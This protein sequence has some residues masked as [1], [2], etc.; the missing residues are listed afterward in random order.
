MITLFENFKISDFNNFKKREEEKLKKSMINKFGKSKLVKFVKTGDL[1]GIKFL[2]NNKFDL[3][4]FDS[5]NL[6]VIALK[7]NRMKV[8]DYLT[9]QKYASGYKNQVDSISLPDIIGRY[10]YTNPLNITPKMIEELKIITKYGFS[11]SDE[12][13]NYIELYFTYSIGFVNGEYKRVFFNGLL[14]FIDWLLDN[15][16]ENYKLCKDFLP[17]DLKN[18]YKYLENSSKYNL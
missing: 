15:Y 17:E 13:Y 1:D 16:P 11:F 4:S 3:L 7:N 9:K 14:P 2:M 6:L 10:D 12:K 18:K 8:F 5:E